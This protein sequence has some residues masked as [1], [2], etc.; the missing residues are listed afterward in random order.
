MSAAM[1]VVSALMLG[2]GFAESLAVHDYASNGGEHFLV[3]FHASPQF[4]HFAMTTMSAQDIGTYKE[5]RLNFTMYAGDR[6]IDTWNFVHEEMGTCENIAGC[7]DIWR[8]QIA[9]NAWLSAESS[10]F[11]TSKHVKA[12]Q[13]GLDGIAVAQHIGEHFPMTKLKNWLVLHQLTMRGLGNYLTSGEQT[14]AWGNALLFISLMASLLTMALLR[15]T[16]AVHFKVSFP[17]AQ[18]FM[19]ISI[20]SFIAGCVPFF[21]SHASFVVMKSPFP[22]WTGNLTVGRSIGFTLLF[23]SCMLFT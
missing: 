2:V 9:R 3:L 4:R 6:V 21:M 16:D 17:Y 13:L 19:L 22:V 20:F 10:E 5:E 18:V 15:R 8:Q 23:T 12:N 1:G 11:I 7:E 14:S